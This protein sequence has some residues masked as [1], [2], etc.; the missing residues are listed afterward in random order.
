MACIYTDNL[1]SFFSVL[2]QQ[3][4]HICNTLLKNMKDYSP[5]VMCIFFLQYDEAYIHKEVHIVSY[6]G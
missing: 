3:D 6:K 2:N 5:F 4:K 1:K